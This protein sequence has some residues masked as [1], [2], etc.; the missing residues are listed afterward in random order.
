ML[1]FILLL[2]EIIG[3]IQDVKQNYQTFSK[4]QKVYFSLFLILIVIMCVVP[5]CAV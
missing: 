5:F 4:K 1:E 2:V 3:T